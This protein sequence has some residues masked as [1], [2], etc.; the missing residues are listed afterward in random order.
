MTELSCG[1]LPKG[2]TNLQAFTLLL[3][4]WLS[5]LQADDHKE[6]VYCYTSF[7]VCEAFLC[8]AT[9]EMA[10]S[11]HMRHS[12]PGFLSNPNVFNGICPLSNL[13]KALRSIHQVHNLLSQDIYLNTA[14]CC[15]P[16]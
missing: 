14:P 3:T 9:A 5:Y 4:Y 2:Q 1:A 13:P 11:L 15:K 10:H 16:T 7:L 6:R 8:T 12:R